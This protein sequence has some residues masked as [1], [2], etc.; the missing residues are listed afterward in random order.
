[1]EQPLKAG[2][3]RR[4]KP[5]RDRP[6]SQLKTRR[7]TISSLVIAATVAVVTFGFWALINQP[8]D[9]PLWPKIVP[10]F[11]FQPMRDGDDPFKKILPSEAEID[12]D[13]ALLARSCQA[14]RTY[15]TEGTMSR[16]PPLAARHGL[17]VTLGAWIS[18]DMDRNRREIE[19]VVRL[20]AENRNVVRV[21]VGNET[22]LR[23]DIPIGQMHKYLDEVRERVNVPVSTAEP[24]HVWIRHGDLADHVDFIAA[25]MLPFWEGV[26]IEAAVDYVV[27]CTE[28]LTRAFPQ[29]QLIIAEVG[30]PSN[31]R[32]RRGAVASPSNQATFLRR[33]IE[34]AGQENYTYYIMEAFDQPWKTKSEGGVG[35]YW[36]VYDVD[37]RPKFSFTEPIVDIPGWRRLAVISMTVAAVI[38]ATLL[39]GSARLKGRGR[40]F[41]AVMAYGAATATVWV[42]YD[43][44]QQYLTVLSVAVGLLL[45]AGM[46]GVVFILLIEAHE[47]AEAIWLSSRRRLFHPESFSG[48]DAA[49]PKVSV[50]LPCHNEPPEMVQRT[51]N[52]LAA[53]DYPDFEVIVVDNNTKDPSVWEPVARHCERLGENFRF[54]HVDPLAGYKAGALNYA[55]RQTH[56]AAEIV[57]V[58]DSDYEVD[59]NWLRVLVPGFQ[60]P[61]TAI[62]QAPQDYRDADKSLFKNMCYSEYNGFFFIG[63]ITRNERNAIIQHGTMT[64]IRRSVLAEVGGWAEWC[65]TEDA[66][67]GL[68][69]FEQGHEA[70][71]VPVSFGRGLMPDNFMDYKKQRFRWAYGAV[72]ILKR[73]AGQLLGRGG[74]LSWGQRY[75]FLSGWLP[76]LADGLNLLFNLAAIL[77]SAAMIAS[78]KTVDPPLVV[79]STLPLVFFIF[80]AAKLFYLYHA[81]VGATILQ[82]LG[83]A[84]AGLSLSH[85]IARAMLTGLFTRRAP[86]LRTPKLAGAHG[87][88]KAIAAA[89]E[90]FLMLATLW[91][92]AGLLFHLGSPDS[93]DMLMWVI[94]LLIQSIP[95]A[96]AVIV[97]W[98]STF[99]RMRLESVSS[100]SLKGLRI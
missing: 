42:I 55:L 99:P 29:K 64:L 59:R 86:F 21:I 34:R 74:R 32:T 81:L 27:N 22:I 40:A 23:G 80:K 48:K 56:P 15:S 68:R 93:P 5:H 92:T 14:V 58:I 90:E 75:H 4:E 63:M 38:L 37:R 57:A 91:L 72:Q 39:G 54:F 66:E 19:D 95:Y 43:Y 69:I 47:W 51:L 65:I 100:V 83:A 61:K 76:W 89:R 78:P 44:T 67:L 26:E 16:I 20:A 79:F 41:L 24:W 25:H 10:G 71:Y 49:F 97:S 33:F 31:G 70:V 1:M 60:V 35:A 96:A 9:E 46:I 17:N 12:E 45:I 62:I 87:L 85:T 73:H 94:V 98:I 18:D 36:G 6:F 30:W 88:L 13:L 52:A 82:T 8:E 28:A 2:E 50:H 53:M 11:S 77:W 7:N 3:G 84:L